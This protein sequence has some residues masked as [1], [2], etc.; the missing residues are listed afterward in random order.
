MALL[1]E[2][3]SSNREIKNEQLSSVILGVDSF[4]NLQVPR[5][6]ASGEL[7]AITDA[8]SKEIKNYHIFDF[9]VTSIDDTTFTEVLT[10]TSI[11]SE[12]IINDTSAELIYFCTGDV[13]SEAP[14]FVIPR[15]GIR[16]GTALNVGTR[17]SLK[18]ASGTV[19][20]GELVI[21]LLG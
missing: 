3:L 19:S 1:R 21:N 15:G 13:G 14:L 11:V 10:T 9:S 16:I 4:N 18:S 20:V 2:V 12:I 5:V 8:A 17:I 6:S 7:L